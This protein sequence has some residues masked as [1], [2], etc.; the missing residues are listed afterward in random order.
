MLLTVLMG[1]EPTLFSEFSCSTFF[2]HFETGSGPLGE[3]GVWDAD[4]VLELLFRAV[5]LRI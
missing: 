2:N 4:T 1:I 5:V 3:T